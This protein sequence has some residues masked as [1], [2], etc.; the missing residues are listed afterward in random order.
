[1]RWLLC[2][3]ASFAWF[4]AASAPPEASREDIRK[5]EILV[6]SSYVL[7][8]L[9]R[10]TTLSLKVTDCHGTVKID[11]IYLYYGDRVV[12]GIGSESVRLKEVLP[13]SGSIRLTA[14]LPEL[15][16]SEGRKLCGEL[17]GGSMIGV[18]LPKYEVEIIK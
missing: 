9:R 7:T 10:G 1:M 3:F 8:A 16:F 2:L 17:H 15:L 12:D 6:R 18:T 5:V 4:P 13:W 14:Y 11:Y